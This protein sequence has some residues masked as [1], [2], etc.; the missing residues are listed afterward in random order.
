MS[1]LSFIGL[2]KELVDVFGCQTREGDEVLV[3]NGG[4]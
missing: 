2:R 1:F 3:A 4:K